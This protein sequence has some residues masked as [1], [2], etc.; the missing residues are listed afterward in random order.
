MCLYGPSDYQFV[1]LPFH[2]L[3]LACR[4]HNVVSQRRSRKFRAD[5]ATSRKV[6]NLVN[7]AQIWQMQRIRQTLRTFGELRA[8]SESMD[9]HPYY[10]YVVVAGVIF[11]E[12]FF[13]I[14]QTEIN[15]GSKFDLFWADVDEPLCNVEQHGIYSDH[16]YCGRIRAVHSL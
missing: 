14:F 2:R 8:T 7:F 12:C 6:T 3:S 9:V 5:L 13:V 10:T 4:R 1:S 15:L 16:I 11:S